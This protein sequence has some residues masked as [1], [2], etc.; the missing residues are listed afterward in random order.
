VPCMVQV[1]RVENHCSNPSPRK[2]YHRPPIFT[3][4]IHVHGL[5][6]STYMEYLHPRSRV[7]EK[8]P[9]TQ[10]V[11]NYPAFYETRRFITF[12]K[13]PFTGPYPKPPKSSPNIHTIF[14]IHFNIIHVA[15]YSTVLSTLN[16]YRKLSLSLTK[17][18]D[19]KGILYIN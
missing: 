11:S 10:L 16:L 3:H 9:V 14:K 8:P 7:L 5:F 17:Y 6:T 2:C 4:S 13:E 19:M 1:P 15:V 12:S 18:H